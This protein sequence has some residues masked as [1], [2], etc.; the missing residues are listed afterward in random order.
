MKLRYQV[1]SFVRAPLAATSVAANHHSPAEPD[2]G[3]SMVTQ[4][5]AVAAVLCSGRTD[6]ETE[7]FC[8]DGTGGSI[9]GEDGMGSPLGE[10]FSDRAPLS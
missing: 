9:G 5:S 7:A 3:A 6:V 10:V 4:D 8:S 1:A 2:I